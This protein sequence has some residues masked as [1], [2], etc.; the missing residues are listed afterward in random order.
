M[1]KKGKG[2]MSAE[3]QE[4]LED[5]EIWENETALRGVIHDS[6]KRERSNEDDTV[7]T[8]Q[9]GPIT[10][11]FTTDWFLREGQGRELLGEWMKKTAVRSQDQR[12]MIQAN[13][14]TF[15]TNSWIHKITKD[16]ESDRCDLCRTLWI[17]EG[18]FRTEEELPKQTLGHI[19]H[20]CEALSTAHIDAHHQCW[21]LIHGELARLTAPEWKFLCVSDEKCLQTI[22]DEITA[23][24]EDIHYL[25]LTQ[26]TIWN[27]ARARE[28][29]HP[30]KTTEHKRIQ[31]G[32]P[33]ETVV[34]ECF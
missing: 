12:R 32:I 20:T 13:S 16:R 26:E 1:P 9:R 7:T 3:G 30:L 28:M 27:P 2:N 31:E 22:W 19:Q 10:S 34:K 6:R 17:A 8:H 33:R 29:A 23:D 15:P 4:L 24:F 14:H 25:N 18:R 21:R 11:T 5:K